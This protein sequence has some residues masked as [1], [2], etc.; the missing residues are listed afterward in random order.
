MAEGSSR[1]A[2]LSPEVRRAR[3]RSLI[4]LPLVLAA[5]LAAHSLE[6]AREWW[7]TGE[8][9]E[10]NLT[11]NDTAIYAGAEWRLVGLRQ[12]G[13]TRSDGSAV[14]LAEFEA[15]VADPQA[16]VVPP[17]TIELADPAGRRWKPLSLTPEEMRGSGDA[18]ADLPRCG[19]ALLEAPKAGDRLRMAETFNVP[20]TMVDEVGLTVSLPAGK[21][22]YLRF[23]QATD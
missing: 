4:A 15:T 20:A 12:V 13:E 9:F 2:A 21:P 6:S 16:I 17:C 19:S 1:L 11:G 22:E 10:R 5:A 8:L 23:D 7:S 14:V 18:A 3:R